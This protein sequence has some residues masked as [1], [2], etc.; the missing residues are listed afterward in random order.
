VTFEL[1]LGPQ[2][3]AEIAEAGNWY[4]ER[5]PGLGLDF[6]HAVEA[7]LTE[8]KQNPLQYQIA[9]NHFRR[10]GLHRFRYNLIYRVSAQVIRVVACVHGARNPKV[11]Q[12]RT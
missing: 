1:I 8:I 6:L 9:W 7:M 11:W 10:A 2:A 4:D 12:E 5:S 3:E